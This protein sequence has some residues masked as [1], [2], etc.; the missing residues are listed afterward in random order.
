[1]I[2]DTDTRAYMSRSGLNALLERNPQNF[3]GYFSP[4]PL[5]LPEGSVIRAISRSDMDSVA[6]QAVASLWCCKSC[7]CWCG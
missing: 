3:N 5:S 7:W 1:M 6:A 2:E 4:A